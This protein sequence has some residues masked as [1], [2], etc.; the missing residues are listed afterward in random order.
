M[1]KSFFQK[2]YNFINNLL[3]LGFL[4]VIISLAMSYLNSLIGEIAISSLTSEISL[5][6]SKLNTAEYYTSLLGVLLIIGAF[7]D[8]YRIIRA[9]PA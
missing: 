1:R 4:S 2:T 7:F 5:I 8:K 3:L 9:L 6:Q